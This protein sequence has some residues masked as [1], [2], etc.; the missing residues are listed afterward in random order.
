MK[1]YLLSIT[2]SQLSSKSVPPRAKKENSVKL[3]QN[4]VHQTTHAFHRHA[5]KGPAIHPTYAPAYFQFSPPP[6][7]KAKPS[8]P[9]VSAKDKRWVGVPASTPDRAPLNRFN[10]L[11]LP[12]PLFC[13]ASKPL[14]LIPSPYIPHPSAKKGKS[15]QRQSKASK[16]AVLV[17]GAA[18]RR[19][20]W[21]ISS[22]VNCEPTTTTTPQISSLDVSVAASK[23]CGD[24]DTLQGPHMLHGHSKRKRALTPKY[25]NGKTTQ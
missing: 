25:P 21:F 8:R 4:Q 10:W 17:R 12:P 6:H 15:F 14:H 9:V 22:A 23:A 24:A 5:G 13:L 18:R 19:V 3:C 20:P 1:I 2:S 11:D 7:Q 16:D